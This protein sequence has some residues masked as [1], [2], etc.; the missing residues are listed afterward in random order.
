MIKNVVYFIPTFSHFFLAADDY[1]F[2]SKAADF[3]I[4]SVRTKR[5]FTVIV[6]NISRSK[7]IFGKQQDEKYYS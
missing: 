6:N 2:S 7:Y 1:Q 5:L 3:R 4:L